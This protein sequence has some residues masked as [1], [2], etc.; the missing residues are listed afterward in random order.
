MTTSFNSWTKRRVIESSAEFEKTFIE[1]NSWVDSDARK[2]I[3]KV[4]ESGGH[5]EVKKCDASRCEWDGSLWIHYP[6]AI[7]AQQVVDLLQATRPDDINLID[8]K[9]LHLWWD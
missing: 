6:K 2:I 1:F 7:T 4:I 8:R 9:I 3:S 5:V